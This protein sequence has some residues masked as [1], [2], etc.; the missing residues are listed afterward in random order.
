M[1]GAV[2]YRT[3]DTDEE[4]A[5]LARLLRWFEDRDLD[6]EHSGGSEGLVYRC[7]K[8]TLELRYIWRNYSDAWSTP[9]AIAD[10]EPWYD[11]PAI[12]YL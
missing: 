7:Q 6:A 4:A 12:E 5:E 3:S 9:L 8:P 11:R 1:Y 10:Y 2:S